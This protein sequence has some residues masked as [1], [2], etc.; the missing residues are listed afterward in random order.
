MMCVVLGF[1]GSQ[2]RALDTLEPEVWMV[3]SHIGVR[4]EPRLSTRASALNSEPLLYCPFSPIVCLLETGSHYA[5]LA[6][7]ELSKLTRPGWL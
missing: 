1:S 3:V 2:K 6:I 7:L 4:I 5:A